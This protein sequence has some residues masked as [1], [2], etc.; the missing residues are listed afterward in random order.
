MHGVAIEGQATVKTCRRCRETKPL[1]EMKR[2]RLYSDGYAAICRTCQKVE[3]DAW[4]KANPERV[5]R[6]E[7]ARTQRVRA[8]IKANSGPSKLITEKRCR[9]CQE[10]KPVVEMKRDQRIN[11]G[12]SSFCNLC[13]RAATVAWQKANPERLNVWRRNRWL[14]RTPEQR[15]ADR[16]ARRATYKPEHV[17]R[18]NIRRNY[19]ITPER[20]DAMLA[21]QGG[22]CAICR[23]A[24]TAFPRR[25]HVD[26]NHSCCPKTPT[27]GQCTRGLLCSHCN[28]SLYTLELSR[29]WLTAASEYLWRPSL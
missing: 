8:R 22:A 26:H 14:A 28:H 15:E 6:N 7:E 24:A 4:R 12:Y 11:D 1:C 16:V 21:A 9:R 5:R 10:T 19:K 23:K 18:L 17:W 25:I 3:V 29:E 2:D 27:C 20:F 13:H